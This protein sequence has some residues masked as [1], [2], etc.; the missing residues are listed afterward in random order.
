[1]LQ[2]QTEQ[3]YWEEGGGAVLVSIWHRNFIGRRPSGSKGEMS[4]VMGLLLGRRPSGSIIGVIM[5]TLLKC[6]F[7]KL[8]YA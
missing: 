1:M 3:H 5:E 8:H 2:G 4:C 6:L 7:L